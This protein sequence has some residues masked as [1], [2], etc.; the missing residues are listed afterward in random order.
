MLF[1]RWMWSISS[2]SSS[3]RRG[4]APASSR[5]RVGSCQVAGE[6]SDAPQVLPVILVLLHHHL[7]GHAG[8]LVRGPATMSG[9]RICS[10]LAR[11]LS[12]AAFTSVSRSA[13]P[14]GRSG[15]SAWARS[16]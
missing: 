12:T 7:H 15:L 1:S 9:K 10:S 11:W 3:P 5:T 4:R 8:V 16:T 14:S 13:R 6:L 2:T